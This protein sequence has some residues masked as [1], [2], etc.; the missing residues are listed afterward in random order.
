L[1]LIAS[2]LLLS[3]SFFIFSVNPAEAHTPSPSICNDSTCNIDVRDNVFQ[4]TSLS[5]RQPDSSGNVT[6]V[7]Q[8]HGVVTHTVT[9]GT[10]GSPD[11]IFDQLLSPGQTFQLVIDVVKYNQILS[12]YSNGVL[13]YYCKLHFGMSA[14]LTI[15]AEPQPQPT[16]SV[17]VTV[18]PS[19]V[20]SGQTATVS[21][22]VV[23]DGN[24]V[25]DATV[26]LTA[27]NGGVLAQTSGTTGSTGIFATT[28]TSPTVTTQTTVTITATATKTGYTSGTD[29]ATLTVTP[30]SQS[31]GN[32]QTGSTQDL[33]LYLAI[34]LI[35][36]IALI[37]GIAVQRRRR[38][39]NK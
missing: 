9:S 20:E 37:A 35:V 7:W 23:S 39:T 14:T 18:S 19:T 8:N 17:T 31:N 5:I 25:P 26:T 22:Q 29:Q 36:L 21:A 28:L 11:G 32:T 10:V 1:T 3:A 33:Q 2:A 4:P 38:S 27:D 30:A 16:L 15:R 6:L 13:P 12:R 34:I 24:Q